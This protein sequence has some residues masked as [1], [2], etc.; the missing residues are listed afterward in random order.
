MRRYDHGVST[1]A[2]DSAPNE[3]QSSQ[4][5]T[6]RDSKEDGQVDNRDERIRHAPVRRGIH[7]DVLSRVDDRLHRARSGSR[8][9]C[10]AG[11]RLRADGD[12]L[13]GRPHLGSPLQPGSH[14]RSVPAGAVSC[15]GR[16]AIL[17]RATARSRRCGLDRR[18]RPS[19]RAG[20]STRC[21]SSWGVSGRVPLHVCAGV[22]RVERG[23]RRRNS[24]EFLL[25]SRYRLHGPGWRIRRR[26]DFGSGLQPGCRYRRLDPGPAPVV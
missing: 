5:L 7:R 21:P 13:R 16:A 15:L 10:S 18:L 11:H 4:R 17:R 22:R 12:D 2:R 8:R 24:R 20:H 14:A 19:G 1:R 3:L 6:R 26:P 23:H 9:D 25:R